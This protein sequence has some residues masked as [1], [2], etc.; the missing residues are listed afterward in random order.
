MK[1]FVAVDMEGIA[2]L[3][4]WDSANREL[5]RRL[6]TEEV[7]TAARGAFAAR[8]GRGIRGGEP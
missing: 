7:N 1:V 6:M 5:E 8:R 3:V 4:T 2:G